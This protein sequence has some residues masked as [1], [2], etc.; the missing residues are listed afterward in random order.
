VDAISCYVKHLADI[1]VVITDV[2][3]PMLDGVNLAR[4]LVKMNPGVK[5][6]ASTGQGAEARQSEFK[7]LG[8]KVIL[9][10]P[11][12]TEKLLSAL[13]EIIHEQ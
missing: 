8:V 5:V 13:H 3:M 7:E 10:K 1:K 9:Q 6:I 4:A 11:Y 12:V 2:M